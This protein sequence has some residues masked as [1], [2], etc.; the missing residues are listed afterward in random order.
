[1]S[2]KLT[3]LLS[4]CAFAFITPAFAQSSSAAPESMSAP[5]IF[6]SSSE[7]SA[8]SSSEPASQMSSPPDISLSE[9]PPP[10]DDTSSSE[11]P[12][13]PPMASADA[14]KLFIDS[15]TAIAKGDA[16][17]RDDAAAKGWQAD[18][19]TDTGPYVQIY[20][21]YQELAGYG[22][23]DIWSSFESFPSQQLG[24]CRID[25]GD[26]DNLIDFKDIE[27]LGLAGTV[28]DQG[29]GNVFGSWESPDHKTLLA[30]NRTD[31]QVQMEFNVLLGPAQN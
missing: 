19:P 2:L 3:P 27:K 18:D 10:P 21:G 20:S 24:Y 1:M 8:V 16:K 7:A 26:V 15:C 6:L 4:L 12:A 5:P 14:L 28:T 29:N 25:F 11:A 23:V 9:E 31:G 30:A 17:A 13:G 22:S